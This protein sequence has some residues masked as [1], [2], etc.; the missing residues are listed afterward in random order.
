M[1]L[2]NVLSVL[3]LLVAVI[4]AA[5]NGRTAITAQRTQGETNLKIARADD[6][7]NAGRLAL[8]FAQ[9]VEK[10]LSALEDWREDTVNTWWPQHEARDKAIE[11]ELRKLDP[12]AE[13]PPTMPLPRLRTR[14][15]S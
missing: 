5:I 13:I 2:A 14:P 1:T 8:D 7:N 3:A 12:G 10:R 9:S 15:P 4:V 11:G 6:E